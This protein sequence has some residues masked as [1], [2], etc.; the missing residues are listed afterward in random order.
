[1]YIR[2][3]YLLPWLMLGFV[4]TSFNTLAD[5]TELPEMTVT[6]QA[7]DGFSTT[8]IDPVLTANPNQ[9]SST[10]FERVPGANANYNGGLSSQPQYRGMFGPRMNVLIDGAYVES[11]GPNWMDPPLHYLPPA[12]VDY[13]EVNRGIAPVSTGSG[14][15]GYA[16]AVSKSSKFQNSDEMIH[17]GDFSLGGR[18]VNGGRNFSGIL[19]T[20]NRNHR[21]HLL[22][23]HDEGD[24][25]DFD[26]GTAAGTEYEKTFVGIGY[27]FTTGVND[28][29]LDLR[30]TNTDN[31]GTPALP[32]D[33]AFFRT[34]QL[35][36]GFNTQAFGFA[37][38]TQF[39]ATDVRHQMDNFSLRPTPD[40][41]ALPL[42]PFVGD[43][44]RAVAVESIGYG[45]TAKGTRGLGIGTLTIGA[46]I[47][48]NEHD[49]TVSDPDFAPFFITNFNDAESDS[50]GI[51]AEWN[52]E[53]MTNTDLELGLRVNHVRTDA[54]LV[55]AFPAVLADTGAVVNGVTTSAQTLRNN[56]NGADRSQDDTNLDAVVKLNHQFTQTVSGEIGL[57]RKTRSPSY[58]ERYLWIP[59]EV[60]AGLGDGNNYIGDPNLDPEVSHQIELGLNI[61]TA[62]WYLSPRVFYRNVD[63]YIQGTA[64]TNAQAITFSGAAAGDATPLVFTNVDARL[65]GFDAAFG[66]T[67]N[68]K[69]RVDGAV[70]Y[71]R[72]ERRDID[73]DLYRIAP[74]NGRLSLTYQTVHW[75]T[76]IEGVAF[77]EQDNISDELTL[78][79]ANP[80]NSND[81]TAGY[82]LLNL[83]TQYNM[84]SGVSFQAGIENVLD[85]RYTNH[86][87]G[88][89]RN[90]AGNIPQGQRLIGPGRNLFATLN[91]RW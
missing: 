37:I 68:R 20:S 75:R 63:D 36:L 27:G 33:I 74:L 44:K 34:N 3:S 87:S 56:F 46:D 23:S 17:H 83:Y 39:F 48:L 62:G 84:D 18:E 31:S 85:K 69:L 1:M 6:D 57:A 40:F 88:F 70:A 14:I 72:G 50:Y 60:N 71:T 15:G 22:G 13:V 24:D 73:D 2:P 7:S 65:Y 55:N 76:S 78:D 9:D 11:G 8:I 77:A 91:Y 52:A 49:A 59:L 61:D 10:L 67:I 38:E 45:W 19:S 89:N 29:S 66:Y 4:T 86:L 26:G 30:R 25:Y 82:A 53:V 43:D 28:F 47:T 81:P 5:H 41:S 32:L 90:T 80:N 51:F 42:P 16:N 12:L 54:G 79:L 35:D 21:I 64:S 58:L